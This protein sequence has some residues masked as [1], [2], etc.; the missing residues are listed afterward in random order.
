VAQSIFAE[1]L[2]FQLAL[3]NA[4]MQEKGFEKR[5]KTEESIT[6]LG[7]VVF[8]GLTPKRRWFLSANSAQGGWVICSFT[9]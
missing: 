1:S 6:K 3:S 7:K 2:I 8:K 5:E 9:I 4:L